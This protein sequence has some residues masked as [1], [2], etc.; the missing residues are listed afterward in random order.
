MLATNSLF[1]LSLVRTEGSSRNSGIFG[2]GGSVPPSPRPLGRRSRRRARSLALARCCCPGRG[3]RDPVPGAAPRGRAEV[4]TQS[5]GRLRHK[6]PGR[7]TERERPSREPAASLAHTHKL[8]GGE[9]EG[10]GWRPGRR[11]PQ[12]RAP[13]L[14]DG[15]RKRGAHWLGGSRGFQPPR[16]RE[17]GAET[18]FKRRSG[19]SS[20]SGPALLLAPPPFPSD[21]D[22]ARGGAVWAPRFLSFLTPPAPEKPGT[23]IGR[24][25]L[26]RVGCQLLGGTLGRAWLPP[27]TPSPRRMAT[28][29][30]APQCWP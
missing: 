22:K 18:Q 12:E 7:T 13:P 5:R 2:Y 23:G 6:S 14:A 26:T 10:G 4:G 11:T 8:G 3:R 30:S 24:L 9:A 29:W 28:A 1:N 17:R 20:G 21:A 27:G 15:G 25:R 19:G 16:R